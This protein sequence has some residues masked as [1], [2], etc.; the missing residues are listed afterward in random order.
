MLPDVQLGNIPDKFLIK[1][2]P[3][4]QFFTF[5]RF[6]FKLFSINNAQTQ[7]HSHHFSPLIDW[8]NDCPIQ[9]AHCR[10]EAGKTKI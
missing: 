1:S 7:P 8:L 5:S 2:K 6:K 4:R 3:L 9:V 10:C